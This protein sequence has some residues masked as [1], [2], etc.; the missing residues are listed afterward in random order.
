MKIY[1]SHDTVATQIKCG[2]IFNN[3]VIAICQPFVPV[4][5]IENRLMFGEN[6][7]KLQSETFFGTQRIYS[8]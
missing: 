5:K 3:H 4:K 2:G 8:N 1:I 7:G 6:I